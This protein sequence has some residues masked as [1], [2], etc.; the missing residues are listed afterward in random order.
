MKNLQFLFDIANI[1]GYNHCYKANEED[2][3]QIEV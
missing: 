3:N 1:K 2:G